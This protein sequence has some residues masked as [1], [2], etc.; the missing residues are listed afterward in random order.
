V[1]AR[2]IREGFSRDGSTLCPSMPYVG[3]RKLPD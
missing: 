1:P 2:A 3:F